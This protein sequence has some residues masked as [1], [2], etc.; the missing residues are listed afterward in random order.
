MSEQKKETITTTR[1][2]RYGFLNRHTDGMPRRQSNI[3]I[4]TTHINEETLVKCRWFPYKPPIEGE[5]AEK[6][7]DNHGEG[8]MGVAKT[9]DANRPVI[10]YNAWKQNDAEFVYYK[11]L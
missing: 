4:A 9:T 6:T 10:G 7:E 3:E 1:I 5:E 11:I 8:Y 2:H